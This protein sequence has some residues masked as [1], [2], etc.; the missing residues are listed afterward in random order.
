MEKLLILG[1]SK[2]SAQLIDTAKKHGVWTI[3][4]GPEGWGRSLHSFNADEI[5]IIDT[6][7]LDKLEARCRNECVTAVLCGISQFNIQKAIELT[8]RLG[9]PFYCTQEAWRYTTDKREFKTLCKKCGVP[10]AKDYSLSGYPTSADLDSI[11]YPCVVKAVDLSANRGMSFCS[12]RDEVV[13]ACE[14]ARSQSGS[15]KVIIEKMMKGRE[16]TAHYALLRGD[17]ALI[18]FCAMFHEP[19]YP[20]N[21]YSVTS[22]A[23]DKLRR[24][25]D[26]VDP[27][28]KEALKEA[29]ATDGVAWIELML[30]EDGHFYVLEMGYRLSGDLWASTMRSVCGFDSYEWLIDSVLG[31][32]SHEERVLPEDQ[33][34]LPSRCG[35]T[36]II[37]SDHRGTIGR[38]DGLEQVGSIR[39]VI[40]VDSAVRV[41]M[42]V[43]AHA[44]MVVI[45]M[46]CDGHSAA[47]EIIRKINNILEI[48]D[49]E[50]S[51]LMIKFDDFTTLSSVAMEGISEEGLRTL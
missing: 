8:D 4:A 13:A 22:T 10:V 46:E 34:K 50:G 16:Y 25:L 33:R 3:I 9:L 32:G 1:A 40:D 41:G 43:D 51:S 44:Y 12:T 6:T 14:I 31:G 19:G 5:W 20:V 37:W 2:G 24:Y 17:A 47:E 30:D 26:E 23:T 36:Y 21:C 29:G 7:E 38:I 45:T 27:F 15:D 49:D 42:Q 11:E 48:E 18:N 35:V 28:F 39:G